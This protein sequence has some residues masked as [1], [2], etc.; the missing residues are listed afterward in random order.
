MSSV[1]ANASR[2]CTSLCIEN[3]KPP[4]VT[5]PPSLHELLSTS[6]LCRHGHQEPPMP[7]PPSSSFRHPYSLAVRLKAL[8]VTHEGLKVLVRLRVKDGDSS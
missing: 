8:K 6:I 1:P 4:S 7:S 5:P 2:T 3:P